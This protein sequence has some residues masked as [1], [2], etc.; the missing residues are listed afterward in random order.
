MVTQENKTCRVRPDLAHQSHS[1]VVIPF[2]YVMSPLKHMQKGM[3]KWFNVLFGSD[4]K[5]LFHI[6]HISSQNKL[7][8]VHNTNSGS[9]RSHTEAD[10]WVNH[11]TPQ[12]DG[13]PP[14]RAT[15]NTVR[16]DAENLRLRC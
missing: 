11:S 16:G 8:F 3:E 5:H 4:S 9:S 6:K 12:I 13:F 2:P 15:Q 1:Y 14:L 10:S 7:T